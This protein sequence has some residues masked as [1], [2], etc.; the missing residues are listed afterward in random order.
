[1]LARMRGAAELSRCQEGS[2][3]MGMRDRY[4]QW[5]PALFE[6]AVTAKEDR[7]AQPAWQ[8]GPALARLTLGAQLTG[9]RI[10][11]HTGALFREHCFIGIRN[12]ARILHR[13]LRLTGISGRTERT[14][15]GQQGNKG[16]QLT[17]HDGSQDSA[18]V[19]LRPLLRAAL[20]RIGPCLGHL[21]EHEPVLWD[22]AWT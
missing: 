6:R 18:S 20:S 17:N 15:T 13:R 12:R 22:R 21:L 9:S 14:D 2:R 8:P 4:G 7:R 16:K 1:M 3:S 10:G 11:L 5:R 19:P